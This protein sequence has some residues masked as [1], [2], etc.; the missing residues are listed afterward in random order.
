MHYSSAFF[1][2]QTVDEI[3]AYVFDKLQLKVDPEQ[4]KNVMDSVY[5]SAPRVG[6]R[7]QARMCADYI[8]SYIQN[9]R[10][11]LTQ[12]SKYN[13]DVQKYD[14]SYGL[15]QFSGGQLGIRKKGPNRFQMRM[16]Y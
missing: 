1:S 10:D 2:Q 13:I 6:L 12:N 3:Q 7:E 9:E 8:V 15:Q 16:I 14:G 5:Q 4:I 11:V